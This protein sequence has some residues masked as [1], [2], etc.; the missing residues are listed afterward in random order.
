MKAIKT[1][2]TFLYFETSRVNLGYGCGNSVLNANDILV[3]ARQYHYRN[4]QGL[5]I[6]IQEHSMG[7]IKA[8]PLHGAKPHFNV[9]SV[10][11]ITGQILDTGSVPGTHGHYNFPVGK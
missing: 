5:V 10:D 8:T 6:V 2:K 1:E 3:Q 9:R 11:K 4:K 7:H